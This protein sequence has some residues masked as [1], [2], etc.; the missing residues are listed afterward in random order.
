MAEASK[1]KIPEPS[2]PKQ[3]KQI[4]Q[5]K[6]YF[7]NKKMGLLGNYCKSCECTYC[8]SHR[9]P[10]NHKCIGNFVEIAKEEIKKKNPNITA[11]KI[12]EI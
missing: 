5:S 12:E 7:C 8:N 11:A 3:S 4:D 2:E 6:C 10:E 9:I 1:F